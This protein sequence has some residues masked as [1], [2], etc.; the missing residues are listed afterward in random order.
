L[1]RLAFSYC[2]PNASL[3]FTRSAVSPTRN[4]TRRAARWKLMA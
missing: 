1:P 3:H 4:A 2:A